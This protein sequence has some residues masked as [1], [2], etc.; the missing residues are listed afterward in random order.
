[1]MSKNNR[2]TEKIENLT[3]KVRAVKAGHHKSSNIQ[4][5]FKPE[6]PWKPGTKSTLDKKGK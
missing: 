5:K 3:D 6:N 4:A 2:L 1:M